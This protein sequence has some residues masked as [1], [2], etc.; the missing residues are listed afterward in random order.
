MLKSDCPSNAR[1]LR[2]YVEQLVVTEQQN[3]KQFNE[4]LV[5]IGLQST[6]L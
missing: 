4:E 1:E 5:R 2:N 3:I 6:T